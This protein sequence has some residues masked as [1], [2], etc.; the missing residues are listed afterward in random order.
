MTSLPNNIG[1]G[2]PNL[3][4]LSIQLNKIRVL[5]TSICEIRSLQ[6][7]DAHFNELHGL[8]HA[9]GRLSNLEVLNLGSNFNNLAE[10]PETVGDLIKL[11][12]LDLSNNQIHAL[13]DTFFRLD[14]LFQLKLDGNPLMIPPMEI[15]NKGL[16]AVLE[17][18]KERWLDILNEEQQ[19][20]AQEA[21]KQQQSGWLAWGSSLLKNFVSGITES[22]GGRKEGGKAST[23]SYL[24]QQL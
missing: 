21:N 10:L 12:D 20:S 19:K 22:V 15:V 13:P 8:P 16:E 17:F 24:D 6:Y 1:Y 14:N 9:I 11:R 3:Q 18:M 23:D 7:L 5:P 2:L 4:K